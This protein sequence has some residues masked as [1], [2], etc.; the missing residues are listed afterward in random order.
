MQKNSYLKIM[1]SNNVPCIF[2]F[3]Q[4]G[5]ERFTPNMGLFCLS[6]DC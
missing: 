2:A 5:T 4:K 3:Y 6:V 1:L